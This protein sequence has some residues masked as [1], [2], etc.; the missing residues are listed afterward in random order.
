MK[1]YEMLLLLKSDMEEEAREA[2]LNKYRE[3]VSS[4][5]GAV[6]STDKWG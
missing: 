5:G 3:I 1:K 2:E 6:E 4:K